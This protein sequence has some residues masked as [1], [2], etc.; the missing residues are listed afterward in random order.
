MKQ[1][2]VGGVVPGLLG[3]GER[4]FDGVE[5][6]G[7]EPIEVMHSPHATLIRYRIGH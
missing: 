6:R 5:D 7:L 3:D 2:R 1:R 4:L